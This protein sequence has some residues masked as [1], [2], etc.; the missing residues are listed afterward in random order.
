MEPVVAS[1]YSYP[2]FLGLFP[3]VADWL[4]SSID[5]YYVKNVV[6]TI[7]IVF[8]YTYVYVLQKVKLSL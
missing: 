2:W 7:M 6:I 8:T 5:F 1:S 4:F 3:Y